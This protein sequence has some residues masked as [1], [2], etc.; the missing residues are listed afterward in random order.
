MVR[1]RSWLRRGWLHLLLLLAALA[2]APQLARAASRHGATTANRFALNTLTA[3]SPAVQTAQRELAA[4]ADPAHP[5]H[6]QIATRPASGRAIASPNQLRRGVRTG[7]ERRALLSLNNDHAAAVA[8]SAA[9]RALA[10]GRQS[11]FNT[12]VLRTCQF[13]QP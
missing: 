6:E 5:I 7:A 2:F 8:D 13:W 12:L 9:D 11:D 4:S 3:A 10:R 1:S